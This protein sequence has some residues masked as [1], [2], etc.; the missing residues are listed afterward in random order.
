[1]TLNDIEFCFNRALSYSFTKKKCFLVF[2]V[3]IF[4]GVLIV[5]CSALGQGTNSWLSMSL[6]FVPIFLLLGIMLSL[7]ILLI[8]IYYHEVKG[9]KISYKSIFF[10]SWELIIGTAYLSIPTILVYLILWIILGIFILLKEISFI[11]EFIGVVLV[12]APF[13]IILSSILLVAISLFALFA[14]SPEIALGH[15]KKLSL[16]KQV[17]NRIKG[18]VFA[19]LLCF[20]ISIFPF[21]AISWMLGYTAYLTE[22]SY[23]LP[24]S[25]LSISVKWFFILFPVSLFLTPATIFFFNFAAEAYNLLNKK[26]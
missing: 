25:L 26:L 2:P 20:L 6:V 22:V 16:A 13:A 4:C 7:A 24:G 19:Y 8:R 3:L 17:V 10:S 18:N 1:M 5:F 23:V 9:I 15:K 21:G 11:G 14:L 12:F